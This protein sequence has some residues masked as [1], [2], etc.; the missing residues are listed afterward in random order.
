MGGAAVRQRA[1]KAE[2]A[3]DHGDRGGGRPERLA[4]RARSH[5]PP[6]EHTD[7]IQRGGL[8]VVFTAWWFLIRDVLA[9]RRDGD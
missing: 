6:G 4:A 1:Q 5:L 8:A 3:L 9:S 2:R 7:L